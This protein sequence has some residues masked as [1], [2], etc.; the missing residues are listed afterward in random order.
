M[1]YLLDYFKTQRR[2][3]LTLT[4]NPLAVSTPEL[5]R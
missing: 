4:L 2:T 3:K 5:R 1:G